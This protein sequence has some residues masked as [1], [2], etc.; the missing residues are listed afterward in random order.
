MQ[1]SNV[2]DGA[3][4]VDC[5]VPPDAATIERI[6]RDTYRGEP[7]QGC[8]LYV[9]V[10]SPAVVKTV[11]DAGWG[12]MTVG[13]APNASMHSPDMPHGQADGRRHAERIRALSLPFGYSHFLDVE[14]TPTADHTQ[15][16]GYINSAALELLELV[17]PG[18]YRGWGMNIS[19]EQLYHDL[20]VVHYWLSSPKV[21]PPA[22]RGAGLV[23]IIENITLGSHRVDVDRHRVDDLG[24]SCKWI[25]QGE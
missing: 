4:L 17:Q 5:L 9:E 25:T 3:L 13:E 23:Q 2:P 14:G 16:T 19:A 22:T 10:I 6:K 8:I 7:I 18:L 24:D 20:L 21:T 15:L 12:L 1:V 11:L